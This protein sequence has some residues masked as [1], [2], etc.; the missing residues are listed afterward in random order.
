MEM[1]ARVVSLKSLDG[2]DTDSNMM[3][4]KRPLE[5][6]VAVAA[7]AAAAQGGVEY[8][9]SKKAKLAT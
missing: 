6:A 7:A 9:E 4:L 3:V 5:V 1:G 2:I 8:S